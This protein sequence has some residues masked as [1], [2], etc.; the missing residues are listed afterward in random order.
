VEVEEQQL[1]DNQVIVV[2]VVVMVKLIQLQMVLLQ[3]I[4]LEV[5]EVVT[6]LVHFYHLLEDKEVVDH[7]VLDQEHKVKPIKVEVV[8]GH[9]SSVLEVVEKVLL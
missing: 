2:V 8:V 1:Q 5:V 6:V 3:F 7:L 9:L 4:M